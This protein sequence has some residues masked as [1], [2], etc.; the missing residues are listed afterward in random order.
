MRSQIRFHARF[1]QDCLHE[2][3]GVPRCARRAATPVSRDGDL[4]RTDQFFDHAD[5]T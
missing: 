3:A 5:Y 4:C 1:V 2:N